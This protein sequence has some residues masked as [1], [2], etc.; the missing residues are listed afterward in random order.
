MFVLYD[1]NEY[2]ACNR[3]GVMKHKDDFHKHPKQKLRRQPTC[4]ACISADTVRYERQKE[5]A[6]RERIESPD[7]VRDRYLRNTYGIS[8]EVY[9]SLVEQQDS[10]CAICRENTD[11]LHVDHCHMTGDV[12]ALLCGKCNRGIGMFN[13]EPE[14]LRLA[15]EYLEKYS[16]SI[17]STIDDLF[18]LF[19]SQ[20]ALD[21]FV[22][23]LSPV[24]IGP[25]EE[26]Q[27]ERKSLASNRGNYS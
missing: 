23:N 16:V 2:K 26:S 20:D 15:A 3:C 6:L 14:L 4:K 12:R 8:L 24:D 11:D 18:W 19:E 5:R 7:K 1:P 13:D 22:A 17:H 10:C 9:N 21:K 25:Y 27:R